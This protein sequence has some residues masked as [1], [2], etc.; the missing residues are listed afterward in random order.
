M[1][2]QSKVLCNYSD[3]KVKRRKKRLDKVF[4]E[5]AKMHLFPSVLSILA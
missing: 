4:F 3:K 1:L 5:K 2:W